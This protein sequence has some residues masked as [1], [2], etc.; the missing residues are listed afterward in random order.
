MTQSSHNNKQELG[1][2]DLIAIP[3][4]II[5]LWVILYYE[6]IRISSEPQGLDL[7]IYP[8]V[9]SHGLFLLNIIFICIILNGRLR[10]KTTGVFYR[11][12]TQYVIVLWLPSI[13]FCLLSY[14]MASFESPV[15][16]RFSL[17][18]NWGLTFLILFVFV[19]VFYSSFFKQVINEVRKKNWSFL[20]E[21][22]KEIWKRVCSFIVKYEKDIQLWIYIT[23]S[24]LMIYGLLLHSMSPKVEIK[25][26]KEVFID[27]D[28][29]FTIERSGY[30]ALPAITEVKLNNCNI[31]LERDSKIYRIRKDSVKWNSGLNSLKVKYGTKCSKKTKTVEVPYLSK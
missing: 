9:L 26:H 29:T 10:G 20:R 7:T 30:I 16:H 23:F 22:I 15:K 3:T 25:F 8:L 14:I 12:S 4:A 13:I 5:S 11:K 28:V 19:I 1:I 6:I 18:F 31:L 2:S 27:E 24:I 17:V 21:K